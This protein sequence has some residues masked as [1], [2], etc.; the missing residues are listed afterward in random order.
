M[1]E[2]G[3][4]G[5]VRVGEG[6]GR[7]GKEESDQ[8]TICQQFWIWLVEKVARVV[9]TNQAAKLSSIGPER[10][11]AVTY[12]FLYKF[13]MQLSYEGRAKVYTRGTQL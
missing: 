1:K 3:R 10:K 11:A 9:R 2:M 4:G 6:R 12:L 5:E 13:E 8:F 7:E